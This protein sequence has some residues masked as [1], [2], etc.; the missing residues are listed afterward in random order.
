M[1]GVKRDRSSAGH[2]SWTPSTNSFRGRCTPTIT[3]IGRTKNKNINS[4]TRKS[5]KEDKNDGDTKVKLSEAP[6]IRRQVGCLHCV[7]RPVVHKLNQLCVRDIDGKRQL[8]RCYLAALHEAQ[9]RH[10]LRDGWTE[11][12][13]VL[14]GQLVSKD[15]LEDSKRERDRKGNSLDAIAQGNAKHTPCRSEVLC[16]GEMLG[17]GGG[18][19]GVCNVLE[20]RK[21]TH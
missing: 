6:E 8:E 20:M 7:V 3:T 5:T 10:G 15:K 11:S 21:S 13:K 14:K 12:G 19:G 4:R 9:L 16:L 1:S 2:A 18:G 17:G